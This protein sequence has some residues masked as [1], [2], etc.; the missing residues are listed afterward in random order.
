MGESQCP[1]CHHVVP[2]FEKETFEA[3]MSVLAAKDAEIAE[4]RAKINRAD[5]LLNQGAV[6]LALDAL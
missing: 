5:Y 3:G 6:T 4:L 2:G 1:T